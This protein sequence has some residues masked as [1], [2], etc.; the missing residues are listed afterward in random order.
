MAVTARDVK[1][2]R[3]ATG[4]G[5]MDAKR[6]LTAADG[7]MEAARQMLREQGLAKA[8]ARSA[9]DNDQGAVAVS[10]TET[11]A[12]IVQLKCE[13]DFS[14]KNEGFTS[15]VQNLADAVLTGGPEAVQQHTAAIED[16]KLTLKENI[17]IG[18]VRLLRAAEGNLVDS[19]VHRQDGRGVN[20][21]V[22]EGSGVAA[23]A[24]HQVALHVAFA[25]PQF[26]SSDQVDAD[27]VER[28]RAALLE[29]TKAEGKPQQAWDKIVDGRMRGWYA[30]RVLLEQGLHGEKTTVKDSIGSGSIVGFVQVLIG[31]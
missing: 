7:D 23:E 9:R 3:D 14:A 11:T 27:E 5:M 2:L 29:I 25:K 16:L 6:A 10:V 20:A 26:L 15:L 13:T 22:V 21:V 31:D 4:A 8:D 1:T 17:E 12:A 28:E 24:L 18:E 30:E 19:Y